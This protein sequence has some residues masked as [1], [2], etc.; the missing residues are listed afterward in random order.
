[1]C[2]VELRTIHPFPSQEVEA[3][4]TYI[5]LLALQ[6]LYMLLF[7]HSSRRPIIYF[8]L[9]LN[10]FVDLKKITKILWMI[11]K[12][13]ASIIA[14]DINLWDKESTKSGN[15]SGSHNS[16]SNVCKVNLL[17]SLNL[18]SAKCMVTGIEESIIYK[19]QLQV[20][21]RVICAHI[22]PHYLENI[23][24]RHLVKHELMLARIGMFRKDIASNRN[25]LFLAAPIEKAFDNLQLCFIPQE[26]KADSGYVVKIV[27]SR[28]KGIEIF[29][30]SEKTIGD[31]DGLP[32]DW[33]GHDPFKTALG[34]HAYQAHLR[35]D[36]NGRLPILRLSPDRNTDS[37]DLTK[38]G[39]SRLETLFDAAPDEG[40]V[41]DDIVDD[42][43]LNLK[44]LEISQEEL[45][46]LQKET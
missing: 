31:F 32:V 42:D 25:L 44:D 16:R 24:S 20:G 7:V 19:N 17:R 41:E 33:F 6:P 9:T 36:S 40:S 2:C 22:M 43:A 21:N 27:D 39:S 12:P 5:Y 8:N 11:C 29:E 37:L 45:D 18:L 38:L 15:S 4:V 30:G 35:F 46:E 1:M 23:N 13:M 26:S 14:K 34:V 28:C 3:Q 10:C